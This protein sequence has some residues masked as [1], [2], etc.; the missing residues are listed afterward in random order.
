M[1]I[2]AGAAEPK[3]RSEMIEDV[4]LDARL[5][6]GQN[7]RIAHVRHALLDNY[8]AEP[9]KDHC[10]GFSLR[11]HGP[12]NRFYGTRKSGTSEHIRTVSILPAGYASVWQCDEGSEVLQI[13]ID[14]EVLRRHINDTYDVDP[15]SIELLDTMGAADPLLARLAPLLLQQLAEPKQTTQLMLDGIEQVVAAH[16]IAQYSS[17]APREECDQPLDK[18][19]LARVMDY[20]RAHLEDDI[21]LEDLAA[22][23]SM[24]LYSFARAFKATTGV[25]PYQMLLAERVACASD[26]LRNP[27]MTLAEIAY[28]VGFSS[29]SHMTTTFSKQMG[30]T[31]GRYRKEFLR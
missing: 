3:R 23:T 12:V 2:E 4:S 27:E 26:L 28:A 31:P 17:S 5:L 8:I 14:E 10:V 19:E 18:A 16:L 25:S 13:Y 21:S 24:S 1:S 9:T 22:H 15:C 7:I 11:Q 30:V 20:M 6:A 29:Q